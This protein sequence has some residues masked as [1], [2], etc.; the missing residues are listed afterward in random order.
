MLGIHQVFHK[1]FSN[2]FMQRVLDIM[3][4]MEVKVK[5]LLII[6]KLSSFLLCTDT[7]K[8]L[9]G[10]HGILVGCGEI[11]GKMN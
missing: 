7:R 10:L 4:N 3:P 6:T 8:R 2:P 5:M 1:R 11:L 9:I